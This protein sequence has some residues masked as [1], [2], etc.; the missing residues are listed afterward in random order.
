MSSIHKSDLVCNTLK[1]EFHNIY[2]IL[3]VIRHESFEKKFSKRIEANRSV[4]T[5]KRIEENFFFRNKRGR[6]FCE[7]EF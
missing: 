3:N 2:K 5:K 7:K 6:L 4:V 1:K